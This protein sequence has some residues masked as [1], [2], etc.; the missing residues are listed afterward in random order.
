VEG[1]VDTGARGTRVPL[2]GWLRLESPLPWLGTVLALYLV[3]PLAAF[4]LR[5]AEPGAKGFG[6]PGLFQALE[7][8]VVTASVSTLLLGLFGVPLGYLLAR[9]QR[10]VVKAL[11]VAVQLPLALPPLT[12]GIL[13]LYVA[14]P[15]TPV[16][17]FFGGNLTDTAVGIVLAQTFVAAPFV[18]VS[19]RSAFAAVPVE[20][21]ESAATLGHSPSARLLRVSLPAAAG[22][23][24][25]GLLLGWLRAFGEY[26]ATVVLAY[27]PYS[28]PVWTYV[29]FSSTGVQ[30]TMAPTALAVG[31]AAVVATAS[32]LGLRG[33]RRPPVLPPARPPGGLPAT[34]VAFELSVARGEFSLRA[35]ARPAS[36]RLAL[37][38]PSGSGKSLTLRCLAG[39]VGDYQGWVRVGGQALDGLPPEA[40]GLGY[41]PQ[42]APLLP[43]KDVWEQ[44]CFGRGADPALAAS[45]LGT[46][47][48]SGLE[49]RRPEE[50]SGG[51]R[52]R[53]CL[54]QVLA[55]QPRL[56]LLDEPFSALDATARE[57]ARQELRRLQRHHGLS[58]VLVT[59]DPREAALLADDVVV[60]GHG[61][62]LQAGPTSEVM[63]RPAS[64]AVAR[65]LG[66]DNIG[67][68]TIAGHALHAQGLALAPVASSLEEGP[69]RWCVRAGDVT[70]KAR[71]GHRAVV[72]DVV[73][74]GA[75]AELFVQLL[76][77]P[78]LRAVSSDPER[79]APGAECAVE[80]VPGRLSVWP[81][82]T[83]EPPAGRVDRLTAIGAG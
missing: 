3:L 67:T 14:G 17:S 68:G 47:G 43:G 10:P 5:L 57:E 77:G 46:L 16:G 39:L 49:R 55:R 80:V 28:L 79:W 65:L 41:M 76:P 78:R 19:A 29:Q 6:Q 44:V 83:L 81:A 62:V 33:R 1:A 59:H 58:S 40:R 73:S 11:G 52:Q 75:S 24:R 53:V 21:E 20:L 38:G 7:V 36:P 26:G 56:V 2:L 8:S 45:W 37:L 23:I 32:R 54:A 50:L 22:G 82:G 25:A 34:P 69:A 74:L 31:A 63:A 9:S 66:V 12:A 4:A 71:G 70:V 51:Q 61:R 27:H 30:A 13:L 18:V 15:Y 48:L 42:G 35:G 64:P 60:L 72:L